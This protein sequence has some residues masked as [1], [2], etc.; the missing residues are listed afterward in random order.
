MSEHTNGWEP[1]DFTNQTRNWRDVFDL[2]H[3]D[4]GW[5]MRDGADVVLV[6]DQH[7]LDA[8]RRELNQDPDS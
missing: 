8:F 5:E 4:D 3:T 6:W 2:V 7:D 1:L